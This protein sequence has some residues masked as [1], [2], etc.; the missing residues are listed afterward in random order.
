[1]KDLE[2]SFSDD[3]KNAISIAQSIAREFSNKNISPGH[4]LKALLHKD[5]G[6]A[7]FL[8]AMG[9]DIY[10]LEEWAEVRIESYPKSSKVEENPQADDE[11][12][13]VINEA[14]NIR[15]KLSSD[16]IDT[17]CMLASLST[18]GVGFT[19]EQLKTFPLRGE[20]IINSLVRDAELKEAVGLP[21]KDKSR[22]TEGKKHNAILKYCIDKSAVARQG[23]LD[24]VVA[25]D[26]EIRM[27]AEVLGR[28]SKPNVILI[29]DPGVG[30][31]AV[32]NGLVQKLAENKIGG[33]LA[34]TLVFEL[35]FGSL[36]AGASYKGEVED[37][38][39]NI[40]AE[41]KQYEKAILF[42]D[43]IHSLLDKQGGASGAS[44]LLKPELA[45]GEITVIGATSVDN[46]TKYIESDEAFSR[47]FETIRI[48]EPDETVALRML[49]EVIPCYERHHGL[50]IAP[51]V[52]EESIRLSK[53]YLKERALPDAAVDLLDRTMAA[54]KMVSVN[55]A[56]DLRSLKSQLDDLASNVNGLTEEELIKELS[57]FNIHLR[58]RISEVLF[59]ALEDDKD[60]SKIETSKEIIAYLDDVI[61][62]LTDFAGQPHETVEK[63]DIA[64]V[65][66]HKTGIPIG[67]LQS[68]E[69]ERLLSTE[70]Y[71]KQRVVGQDHAIKIITE[72]I[73]E[74]RS[75]L[76]KAG[77]PIGSFFFLGPTGTGKTELAKTLAEFLFQ[78][79]S[80]LIRFDMS[81][82]KEEHSAALLYGAPPGYVGYEEGG[83][84]VNKIRQQPYAVVLF[85]EIEK[86]HTSVFDIFLQI[87][88]EGKLHDR[89]GKEGDFS[90]AVI[91]FTSNIASQAISDAFGRGE[92]P[93]SNEIME[94][95]SGYFRPEFLGRLTEIVPFAPIS[96]EAIV[97]IFNIHLKNL[98][99]TLE[100]QGI[101]LEIEEKAKERLAISG[102]TPKYGA[103]PLIGVIRSELRRPLSRKI[104]SGEVTR[105]SRVRVSI[106]ANDEIMWSVANP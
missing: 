6:L 14:D 16:N 70:Q 39:K 41:I 61:C 78:D 93:R 57:W 106:G 23:R 96:K 95:M 34:G 52:I 31:T 67:K 69:R 47:S 42:I 44:G 37:R 63:S 45:K 81:E 59:C 91:L 12:L 75:G 84:L 11:L 18:P 5:I 33:N 35:D 3:L 48:E 24:P 20:E 72:A 86:A 79:E 87:L 94:I 50:T 25:R 74:S 36:I 105:G 82:F 55:S 30:K 15:L 13:A 29:G 65:V 19:Y 103:R 90:N 53:R 17:V 8:E 40:I 62:K 88:D 2:F 51:D 27:I 54:V 76:S 38:L 80:A 64:A 4:L 101:E 99:K 102:F 7:S 1:M 68:Q 60:V 104:I 92:I 43:E 46:Y 26:K 56:D 100:I 9:K 77:Q 21:D 83:L 73:L 98:F 66:S 28:R 49:K 58:D 89:L 32:V 71:L 97:M 10:Y 22:T 85:D